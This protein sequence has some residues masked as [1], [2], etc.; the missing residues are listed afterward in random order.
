ME[1]KSKQVMKLR[2]GTIRLLQVARRHR[3]LSPDRRDVV[4]DAIRLHRAD[5][6]RVRARLSPANDLRDAVLGLDYTRQKRRV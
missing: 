3:E 4:A 2:P 6:Y 5:G 1:A